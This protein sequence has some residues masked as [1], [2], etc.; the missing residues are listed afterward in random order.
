MLVLPQP[1]TFRLPLTFPVS[2]LPKTTVST[3]SRYASLRPP[4]ALSS[5][6]SRPATPH[7]CSRPGSSH[8]LPLS[9]FLATLTSNSQLVENPTTLSPA[10][11]AL[12]R[13]VKSKSFVCHSYK[14][15][16]GVWVSPSLTQ[17]AYDLRPTTKI[18]QAES[19]SILLCQNRCR[20][21]ALRLPNSS[22]SF[23]SCPPASGKLLHLF[24]VFCIFLHSAKNYLP[25]CH[26][27]PSSLHKS[28]GWVATSVFRIPPMAN[29]ATRAG[30]FRY[31][32]TSYLVTS[33][34]AARCH[35]RVLSPST[36]HCSLSTVHYP[37]YRCAPP[38]KVPKS[39]VLPSSQHAVF[40]GPARPETTP[41][42]SVSNTMRADIRFGDAT[43]PLLIATRFLSRD[44]ARKKAWVHRS[45]RERPLTGRSNFG[46]TSREVRCNR[47]GKAGSVR[48]G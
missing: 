9:P 6:M 13:C 25:P 17:T 8:G 12:T 11:A 16:P 36:V 37:P 10:F 32:I 42:R 34:P 38:R 46:P 22:S 40:P 7:F 33:F 35:S 18:P 5:L 19:H 26:Q 30:S 14:K 43:A 4:S 2:F 47:T 1:A 15:P 45:L 21:P 27:L 29:E 41:L 28:T 39:A 31:L 3:I 20:P 44:R 23:R 48:M 24:A